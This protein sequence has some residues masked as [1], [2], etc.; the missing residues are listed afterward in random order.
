MRLSLFG[1][2]KEVTLSAS[3]EIARGLGTYL[4]RE[5]EL[6]A[7]VER[8]ERGAILGGT[9]ESFVPV[10]DA[11]PTVAWRSFYKEVASDWEGVVD[12]DEE[13]ERD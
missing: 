11:D 5:V 12:I 1:E 6:T 3:L 9:L 8:N 10:S 2:D 13:L 4:L 7:S